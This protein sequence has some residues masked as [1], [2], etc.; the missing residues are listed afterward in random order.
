MAE[1]EPEVERED[2]EVEKQDAEHVSGGAYEAYLS[3]H[4]T[5]QGSNSGEPPKSP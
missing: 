3:S 5:K 1:Q 2:L 4:G